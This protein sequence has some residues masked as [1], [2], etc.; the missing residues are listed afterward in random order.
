M[1]A[2]PLT[3]TIKRLLDVY[4]QKTIHANEGKAIKSKLSELQG[5]VTEKMS[6]Q[7]LRVVRVMQ[8]ASG[9]HDV[10]HTSKKRK[11]T[12]NCKSLQDTAA[13]FYGQPFTED[14][15][16]EIISKVREPDPNAPE[17]QALQVKKIKATQA[18]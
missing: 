13:T 11:C 9:P 18:P 16:R 8:H 6:Q 17:V 7:G 4:H 12:F 2:I 14:L 1:D 3:D 15:L 10:V 5:A